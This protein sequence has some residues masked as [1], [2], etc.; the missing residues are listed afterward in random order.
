VNIIFQILLGWLYGHIFEYIA[1]KHVLHNRKKFKTVF[2]NHFKKHHNISRKNKMYD[3]NYRNVI[4]SKFETIA[5]SVIVFVHLPLL[6][7]VP[8]FYS[9]IVWS[10]CAYYILHKLAHINTEWGKK[11]LPWHYE[12]H[13]GKNQNINWGVRLP[14]I[15]KVMKTSVY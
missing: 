3:E 15:D 1:H 7:Y 8:Y 9:M 12:H 11:W 2:R 6:F 14:I 13:M 4:S 5:L 10:V